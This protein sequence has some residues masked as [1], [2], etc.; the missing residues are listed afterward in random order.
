MIL[1]INKLFPSSALTNLSLQ[2][3]SCVFCEVRTEL[4]HAIKSPPYVKSK[5]NSNAALSTLIKK[6]IPVTG[7]GGP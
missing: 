1:R 5:F 3:K 6:T 7:R 2:W 4:I